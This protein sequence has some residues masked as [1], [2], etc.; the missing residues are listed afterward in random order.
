MKQRQRPLEMALALSAE[1]R[2]R[3][4]TYWQFD[5]DFIVYDID[6]DRWVEPILRALMINH[7]KSGTRYSLPISFHGEDRPRGRASE[8]KKRG[9]VRRVLL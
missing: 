4:W 5:S 9:R 1:A 8:A 6:R 3:A 2:G 7:D